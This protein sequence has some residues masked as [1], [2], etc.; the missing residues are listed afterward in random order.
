MWGHILRY[1]HSLMLKLN[2]EIKTK[3]TLQAT[4]LLALVAALSFGTV[5]ATH[6]AQNT[7]SLTGLMGMM[8]RPGKGMGQPAA[9]GTVASINGDG[10][11]LTGANGTTYTVDASNA[12]LDINKPA[13]TSLQNS[14]IMTGDTLT[15]FGTVSGNNIAATRIAD[16]IRMHGAMGKPV[17]G[18]VSA[19]SG[20]SVSLAGSNGTTYT[21]DLSKATI[22]KFANNAKSIIQVSAI[23]NGDTLTVFGAVTGSDIAATHA[24][25]GQPPQGK[26]FGRFRGGM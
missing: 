10:I 20:S 11:T 3:R 26:G 17:T 2:M 1:L 5:K 19:V 13:G 18:T 21:V 8:R 22:D 24:I 7:K 16:G 4:G 25:D 14:G 12:A 6:A 15:V 9:S 23:Q